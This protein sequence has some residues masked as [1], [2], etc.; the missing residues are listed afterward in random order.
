VY[1]TLYATLGDKYSD[2][3]I[4]VMENAARKHP[5][6]EPSLRLPEMAKLSDDIIHH[7]IQSGEGFLMAAD[8]LHHAAMGVKSF[9]ML[10]PF[11][12]LPNHVCGRGIVKR[13]KEIHGDIQIL[14]LDYDPDTS[15]ANIENRL[16]MLIM[17]AIG[18]C[19]AMPSSYNAPAHKHR[20]AHA[21]V[22]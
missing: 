11:G 9:V 2:F 14:P 6:F 3:A 22:F 7:S 1:D 17:N 8:I 13:L 20:K 16:Q 15:F 5:L 21:A 4:T 19:L 12:C 10:Q 18:S